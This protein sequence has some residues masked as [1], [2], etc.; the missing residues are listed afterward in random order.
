VNARGFSLLEAMVTLVIVAMVM[1]LLMQSLVYVLG[2]RERLLRH[3]SEARISALH[4]QWFRE[5]VAAALVDAHDGAQAFS[6]SDEGFALLGADAL[7]SGMCAVVEWR[8][9]DNA[10]ARRLEY[11]E[12]G[13]ATVVLSR[14]LEDARF[15]YRDRS[16]RWH[17]AWPAEDAPDEHMPRLVRLSARHDDEPWAWWVAL[18]AAP[19]LPRALT[20]NFDAQPASP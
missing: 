13:A 11:V 17:T 5:S 8:I 4:E 20:M 9:K 3:E 19:E 2:V 6:G 10:G 1:A 15:E 14:G 16:G 18:A 12:E 7:R